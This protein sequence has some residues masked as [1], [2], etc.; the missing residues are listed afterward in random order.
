MNSLFKAITIGICAIA[1]YVC[2]STAAYSKWN[3]Q[4][5]NRSF[6]LLA[7]NEINGRVLLEFKNTSKKIITAY[8]VCLS[9]GDAKICH[10]VDLAIGGHK[11]GLNPG[12]IQKIEISKDEASRAKYALRISAIFDDASAEGDKDSILKI[13]LNRLGRTLEMM[14][15]QSI[16]STQDKKRLEDADINNLDKRIGQEADN[17]EDEKFINEL[18]RVGTVNRLPVPDLTPLP[19]LLRASFI[20]GAQEERASAKRWLNDLK[21]KYKSS[22]KSDN[23]QRINRFLDIEERIAERSSKLNGLWNKSGF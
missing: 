4:S 23:E 3:I 21:M 18:K 14:R 13:R 2:S 17:W 7:E 12:D 11:E 6:E 20:M 16:L 1:I 9:D 22:S 5:S 15:L 19:Q 10:E 8:A